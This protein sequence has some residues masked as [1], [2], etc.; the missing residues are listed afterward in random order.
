MFGT[1][2]ALNRCLSRFT[3]SISLSYSK[4]KWPCSFIIIKGAI[5]HIYHQDFHHGRR[6][7]SFGIFMFARD[8]YYYLCRSLCWPAWFTIV[9]RWS[10]GKDSKYSASIVALKLTPA[11]FCCEDE[12]N[13]ESCYSWL[14]P[15]LGAQYEPCI[16][17]RHPQSRCFGWAPSRA[18]LC[19][20]VG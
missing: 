9:F 13:F 10:K 18:Q 16:I 19:P 17:K 7:H 8:A 15:G 6:L 4:K 2:N 11:P 14:N 20:S 12:L 1:I 3:R 5:I